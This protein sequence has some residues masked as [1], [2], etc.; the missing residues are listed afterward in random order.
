MIFTVSNRQEL[1]RHL[2]VS[3]E[4]F[5]WTQM[6]YCWL[7]VGDIVCLLSGFVSCCLHVQGRIAFSGHGSSTILRN[8]TNYIQDH[9]MSYNYNKAK[10]LL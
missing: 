4:V 9:S 1:D 8:V 3:F 6:V 10:Y 2:C 7:P 5:I